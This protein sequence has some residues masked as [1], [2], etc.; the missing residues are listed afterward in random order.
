MALWD[1]LFGK[2][3]K[4]QQL[5]T[6]NAQQQQLLSQLLSGIGPGFG[7][8]M[9]RM[10]NLLAGGPEAYK[11]FE[12]PAMRQFNQ[13][14]VPGIAERFSGMGAGAQSSSAFGQQLGAAGSDLATR[15]AQMRAGLQE[16]QMDRLSQLMNMG[17]GARTFENIHRPA[18]QGLFGAL[19]PGFGA[20]IGFALPGAMGAGLS[21][22]WN[23]FSKSKAQTQTPGPYGSSTLGEYDMYNDLTY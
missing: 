14:I 21:G 18:T 22:L 16:S 9:D 2:K 12:E 20:G 19:A 5:P 6:M 3:E 8:G 17:L 7:A 15:L 23:L 4:F 11:V 10:Q 13:E 1:K